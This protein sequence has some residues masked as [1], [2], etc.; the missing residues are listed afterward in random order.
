MTECGSF[1]ATMTPKISG[2]T[3]SASMTTAAGG[4]ERV[5]SVRSPQKTGKIEIKLAVRLSAVCIK[6]T[7]LSLPELC[8]GCCRE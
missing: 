6:Q 4:E 8:S 3:L 5:T 2:T 7:R 1:L